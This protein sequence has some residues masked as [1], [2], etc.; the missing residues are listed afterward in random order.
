MA[1]PHTPGRSNGLSFNICWS[2]TVH[3]RQGSHKFDLISNYT[4]YDDPDVGTLVGDLLYRDPFPD[5]RAEWHHN[6]TALPRWVRGHIYRLVYGW[7]HK[8]L[9]DHLQEN[10][11]IA[12][13][14]G[15]QDESN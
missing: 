7:T 10:R 6:Y 5:P 2:Y 9:H 1:T 8:R 3:T 15:F 14:L 12:H 13:G 11:W 4:E